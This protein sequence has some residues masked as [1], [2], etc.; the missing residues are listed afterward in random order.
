M[1]DKPVSPIIEFLKVIIVTIIIAISITTFIYNM[2]TSKHP[3]T[4]I[5][6]YIVIENIWYDNLNE[7]LYIQSNK[8][9]YE[10]RDYNAYT[11]FSQLH[12]N[13]TIRAS[14]SPY[15]HPFIQSVKDIK[16]Y[17]YIII[18]IKEIKK[19]GT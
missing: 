15:K 5:Y 8:Y 16:L 10:Y 6:H 1:C 3:N 9:I 14:V 12:I 11:Y 19:Y 17:D 2:D 7:K 4:N 13:D 18:E